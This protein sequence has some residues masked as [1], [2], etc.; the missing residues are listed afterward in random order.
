MAVFTDHRNIPDNS[1]GASVA[2]GNFDGVHAGHRAVIDLARRVSES[3]S[4]PLAVLIFEPPPR[5]F[6]QPDSPPFRI[7]RPPKR[8]EAL[9]ALGVDIIFELPFNNEMSSMSPREFVED[10]LVNGLG[11]S[12]LSVGFDF[13]F[14]KGRAGDVHTLEELSAEFG[15]S[16]SVAR[17]VKEHEDKV[18]ST[19][20]RNALTDGRP[21]DAARLLGK[22]WIADGVVEHGEKRGRTI[23][24][25]TANTSLGNL[26]HPKFGIYAV[27]TRIEGLEGWHAGVA[28]FGR[29]PT[30]GDR[31]PLLEVYLFDFDQD[32]Y[33]RH[34][35]VAFVAFL[36]SEEKFE[37]LDDLVEQMHKDAAK[38]RN[39][40]TVQE[41]AEPCLDDQPPFS[42]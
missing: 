40:L 4:V 20:I 10:V 39:I 14:G 15:F 35:E 6:F 8:R 33:D 19:A 42:L 21:D 31:E 28:N 34:M 22:Y 7:M 11:I 13:R 16:L 3:K 27:W 9:K 12:H 38:A 24:F 26:I 29:T 41:K 17:P 32:I 30:T 18:S 36:R 1:R 25:P 23:G 2:L 5:R 37:S